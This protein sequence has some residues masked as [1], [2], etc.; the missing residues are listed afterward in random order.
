[1]HNIM[2]FPTPREQMLNPDNSLV[3]LN[4]IKEGTARWVELLQTIK[5]TG[6]SSQNRVQPDRRALAKQSIV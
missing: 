5:V 3:R 6:V 1:M 4:T 2:R